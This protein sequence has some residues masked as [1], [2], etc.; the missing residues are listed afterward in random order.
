MLKNKICFAQTAKSSALIRVVCELNRRK[1]GREALEE[2]ADG[3]GHEPDR[4]HRPRAA[5]SGRR[6]NL[7]SIS[8]E[9]S[10]RSSEQ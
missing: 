4:H 7:S 6:W 2:A 9:S 5:V 1:G 3:V 10:G 8:A